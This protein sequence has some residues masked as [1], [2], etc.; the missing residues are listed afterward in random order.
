MLPYR[1]SDFG[2]ENVFSPCCPVML[3]SEESL[4]SFNR[5]I[6]GSFFFK[7][8]SILGKNCSIYYHFFIRVEKLLLMLLKF[9]S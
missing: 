9:T 6:I 2:V 4:R 8:I 3:V 7:R 1:I 5:K